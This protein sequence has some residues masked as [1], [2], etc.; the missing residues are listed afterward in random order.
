MHILLIGGNG[1][2]GSHLTDKLLDNNHHVSIL[3]VSTDPFRK[4]IPEVRYFYG[5][6]EDEDLIK[7]ALYGVDAVFHL[8]ST[9]FPSNSNKNIVYDIESN[10]VATISL[11]N[12]MMKNN[13]KRIIYL[14]SGGTVYGPP[15]TYPIPESHALNPISSYGIVKVA[16]EKYLN[17]F[18]RLHGISPLIFRPAN[19]YGPRQRYTKMQG[20]TAH[21]LY[22]YLQDKPVNV[23]GDGSS[24]KDYIYVEDLANAM[25][26][27][28][29]GD[30]TGIFNIGSGEDCSINQIIEGIQE[31]TGEKL[32]VI[33]EPSKAFDVQKM[34]LDI[35]AIK[36]TLDWN[37]STSMK[38]GLE[39]Q[40]LWMKEQ[41]KRPVS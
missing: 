41:V 27:G 16:I 15:Q 5:R 22:N 20:V 23:W 7:K 10:L 25:V 24:T 30:L 3:D 34:Q 9:T 38:D 21:F 32:R 14:S 4:E 33:Y 8:V 19:V 6:L 35:Q 18:Q 2:I 36:E 37:P 28:V 1:F 39:K 26:K 17:L 11:L 40:L 12:N 13:V 31:T 29:E